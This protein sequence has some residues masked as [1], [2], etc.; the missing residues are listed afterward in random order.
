MTAKPWYLIPSFR[1]SFSSIFQAVC[2]CNQA[3]ERAE[4]ADQA[5][6]RRILQLLDSSI[7]GRVDKAA[8]AQFLDLLVCR[9]AVPRTNPSH[10]E[11]EGMTLTLASPKA[12]AASDS[13]T[14]E[15][16]KVG[17]PSATQPVVLVLSK[18]NEQD[19]L[20]ATEAAD[21]KAQLDRLAINSLSYGPQV[22]INQHVSII[23]SIFSIWC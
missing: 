12:G 14:G 4:L 6:Q 7:D 3:R 16:T 11:A 21:L 9:L 8:L 5:L 19:E 18:E 2:F 23:F 17:S 15:S 20:S 13:S 22:K 10:N 1:H